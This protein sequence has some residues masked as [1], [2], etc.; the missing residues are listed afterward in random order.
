MLFK[1][2]QI[3]GYEKDLQ[4][5]YSQSPKNWRYAFSLAE[6]YFESGKALAAMKIIQ[7][8]YKQDKDNYFAGM[9]LA[10]VFNDLE[11]YNKTIDLLKDIKILPYEHATEGRKIYTKAYVGSALQYIEKNQNNQAQSRVAA[12]L[13]WPEHIGVGKPFDP[14][15]RWEHF[16]M[17]YI[18]Q[19]K[20]E[21]NKMHSAL[22][23]IAQF[24]E[25]QLFHS[26]KNHLLGIYALQQ[27]QGKKEVQQFIE[28]LLAA[29]HGSSDTTK[30]L[31][32]F[33]FNNIELIWD[34]AFMMKLA[35][36]LKD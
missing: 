14:E 25:A 10:Q 3:A 15:E 30:G 32:Q 19:S 29:D 21:N 35:S 7:K 17:A 4:Y 16:L 36:F 8:T 26:S 20:G 34:K 24:S 33:Y 27:I 9:L 6:N 18:H 23:S 5:A 11:Q 12:A 31:I 22:E 1:Q 13:L 2:H 28:K